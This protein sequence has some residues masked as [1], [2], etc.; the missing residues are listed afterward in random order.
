MG[1]DDDWEDVKDADNDGDEA[2]DDDEEMNENGGE[3]PGEDGAVKK[4]KKKSECCTRR[5]LVRRFDVYQPFR[6]S[7][8]IEKKKSKFLPRSRLGLD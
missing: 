6:C 4:K 1:G 3:A 8:V 2:G 5:H 7:V